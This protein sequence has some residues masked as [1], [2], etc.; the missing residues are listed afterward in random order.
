MDRP[1]PFDLVF[2]G[3]APDRF[4]AIKGAL[5]AAGTDPRDRD[6]FLLTYPAMSLLRDLRPDDAEAGE[7]LDELTALVHHAYLAWADGLRTWGIPE[8]ETRHIMAQRAAPAV[9]PETAGYIQLPERLVW[10]SLSAPGPWEPLDG[11]F[12]HPAADGAMRVLGVFGLHAARNGFTVAE[13]SGVPGALIARRDG[14]P[15]FTPS[16]EGGALAG[17][18]AVVEPGE[19]VELAGRVLAC[20]AI[21]AAAPENA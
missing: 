8:P 2:S 11:C 19:L 14:T 6:G 4:P 3:L 21:A 12:V 20:R 5:T 15:L 13:A 18:H 10:A 1:T 7:G 16:L 9:A 17:L